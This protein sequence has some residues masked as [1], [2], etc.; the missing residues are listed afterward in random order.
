M[1]PATMD[2]LVRYASRL[3]AEFGVLLVRG[4]A[5]RDKAVLDS[6]AFTRWATAN[7]Q[8]LF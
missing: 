6:G 1:N 2:G 4:A 3:P 8:V 5:A 7:A